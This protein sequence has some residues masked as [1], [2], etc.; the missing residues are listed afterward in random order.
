MHIQVICGVNEDYKATEKIKE[1]QK[2]VTDTK[3][4]MEEF[5]KEVIVPALTDI[6]ALLKEINQEVDTEEVRTKA[7]E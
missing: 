5:S 1:L 4:K 6:E 2:K 7:E 3:T